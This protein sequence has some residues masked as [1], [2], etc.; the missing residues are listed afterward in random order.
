MQ[1]KQPTIL[2]SPLN[3]GL[4]HA[5]R[6]VPL[7]RI[8]QAQRWQVV[9][10]SSGE[11]G[12]FL[13]Q[14]FPELE[15]LEAP[16]FEINYKKAAW[17]DIVLS[18][19]RF[20]QLVKREN[21]WLQELLKQRRLDVVLSDNRY[22]MHHPDLFSILLSHQ[23]NPGRNLFSESYFARLANNFDEIWVPDVQ[24]PESLSGRLSE[25][26]GLQ[27]P[28]RHLGVYS[29]LQAVQPAQIRYSHTALLSGPEGQ[30]ARL[31][32]KI[33]SAFTKL[34]ARTCIVRGR[35][36]EVKFPDA[37][38]TW[39]ALSTGQATSELLAASDTLICRSGYSTLLDLCSLSKPA[40]LIPT[41]GQPEQ[42]YLARRMKE[43]GWFEVTSQKNPKITLSG[44][45]HP[46][47]FADHH[48]AVVAELTKKF[49]R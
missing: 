34:P 40:L 39:V 15:Y 16:H 35:A 9:L 49:S 37:N 45:T 19:P 29:R 8:L 20:L 23:L 30:R 13:Q 6:L 47:V 38:I 32:A 36:G 5:S 1:M 3:W 42:I 26:D 24:G 7:I 31:E 2:V 4:G 28:V 22:G 27:R 48:K 25:N 10:A 14:Y 21:Q 11:A 12:K 41:P 17:L 18:G 43:K 33:R 44:N 46:P